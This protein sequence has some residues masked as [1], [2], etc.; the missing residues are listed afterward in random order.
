MLLENSSAQPDTGFVVVCFAT[1]KA[2]EAMA[3]ATNARTGKCDSKVTETTSLAC[4]SRPSDVESQNV[5]RL[6]RP[7]NDDPGPFALLAILLLLV[8]LI[9]LFGGLLAF[10]TRIQLKQ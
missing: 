9:I 3:P 2:S 1:F 10:S 7:E 8:F 4:K 6:N 5:S